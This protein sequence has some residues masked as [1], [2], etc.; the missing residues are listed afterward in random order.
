LQVILWPIYLF[1]F[2]EKT[3]IITFSFVIESVIIVLLLPLFFAFLTKVLLTNK[4]Q[5]KSKLEANLN[6]LP[7]VFLNLV[8]IALFA[9]NGQLLLTNLDLMW[10][11]SVPILI[12]FVVNFVTSQKIGQLMRFRYP[13]RASLSLTTLARNSPIALAIALSAFPDQPLIAL[14]LIIG[15]LLEL[16]VLAIISQLLLLSNKKSTSNNVS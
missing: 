15:P 3:G 4:Q 12:F 16:P 7:I 5:L 6:L 14:A 13:E 10:I 9:A 11:L 1:I 8:I 2:A